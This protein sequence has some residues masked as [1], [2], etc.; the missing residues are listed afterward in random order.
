MHP[1]GSFR[2]AFNWTKVELKLHQ[3]RIKFHAQTTFNW[4]KVELKHEETGVYSHD[5]R[6]LIELR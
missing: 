6:L 5:L 4:T 1:F 3:N 2:F